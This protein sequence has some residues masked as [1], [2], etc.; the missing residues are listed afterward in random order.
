MLKQTSPRSLQAK[1]AMTATTKIPLSLH[2]QPVV[3][4]SN[5][6]KRNKCGKDVSVLKDT[7]FFEYRGLECHRSCN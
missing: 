3:T 6:S 7:S 1:S 5:R 2:L 4:P